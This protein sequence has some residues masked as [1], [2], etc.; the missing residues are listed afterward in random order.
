ME[1]G[2]HRFQAGYP[3]I[4]MDVNGDAAPVIGDAD[5][6]IGCDADVDAVAVAGES[7]VH[8]VVQQLLDEVMKSVHSGAADVHSRA[9]A[10]GFQPFQ[11]LNIVRCIFGGFFCCR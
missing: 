11:Y 4:G 3:G 10:D 8:C 6:A 5:R 7:L 9:D 2:H 1:R